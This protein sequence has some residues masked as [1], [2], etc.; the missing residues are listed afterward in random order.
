MKKKQAVSFHGANWTDIA[1][2]VENKFIC[3]IEEGVQLHEATGFNLYKHKVYT[4]R[5]QWLNNWIKASMASDKIHNMVLD[6]YK[7][8]PKG[9]K[10]RQDVRFIDNDIESNIFWSLII[11][12]M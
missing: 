5:S 6:F 9:F 1:A 8:A 2:A 3:Y 11:A 4:F 12:E 10:K 7:D